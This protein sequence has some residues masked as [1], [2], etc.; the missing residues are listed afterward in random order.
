MSLLL[1]LE[2]AGELVTGN[3][4]MT[5]GFNS[6][7]EIPV[8]ESDGL[9]IDEI[10]RPRFGKQH[11]TAEEDT[12]QPKPAA[13]SAQKMQPVIDLEEPRQ[14]PMFNTDLTTIIRKRPDPKLLMPGEELEVMPAVE[15]SKHKRRK[16]TK[17]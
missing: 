8:P 6:W 17:H 14:L 2:G 3:A 10:K 1:I 11:K 16:K 13:A 15:K 7:K 9:R 12:E 4:V 5:D